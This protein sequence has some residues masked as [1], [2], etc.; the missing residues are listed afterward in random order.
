MG[1]KSCRRTWGHSR[2]VKSLHRRLQCCVLRNSSILNAS[3]KEKPC[4]AILKNYNVVQICNGL[5]RDPS[6]CAATRA[7]ESLLEEK[8]V[9]WSRVS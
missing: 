1:G 5:E 2:N 4:N 3:V 8:P 9:S 7:A 6:G